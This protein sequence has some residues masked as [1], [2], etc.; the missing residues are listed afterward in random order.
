MY[1]ET[2]SKPFIL[3]MLQPETSKGLTSYCVVTL[4]TYTKEL[5][6]SVVTVVGFL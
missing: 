2:W 6:L 1:N 4:G 3:F 5:E